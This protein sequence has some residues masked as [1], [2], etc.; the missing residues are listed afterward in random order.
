MQIDLVILKIN[1]VSFDGN[2]W[3]FFCFCLNRALKRKLPLYGTTIKEIKQT[4]VDQNKFVF[5]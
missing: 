4:M 3:G 1:T 5:L 2:F